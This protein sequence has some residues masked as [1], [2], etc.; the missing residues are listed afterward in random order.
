MKIVVPNLGVKGAVKALLASGC[1]QCLASLQ[2]VWKL[3][4]QLRKLWQPIIFEQ[5]DGSIMGSLLASYLIELVCLKLAK[6]MILQLAWFTKWKPIVHSGRGERHV[7]I[8]GKAPKPP[9]RNLGGPSQQREE[10]EGPE[11]TK[12]ASG[13]VPKAQS[14]PHP[15]NIGT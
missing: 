12:M 1:T 3:G 13:L 10:R 9:K 15:P 8:T 6:A 4:L 5:V 11:H 7:A 14:F 2:T